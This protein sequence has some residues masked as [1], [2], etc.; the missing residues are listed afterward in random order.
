MQDD[1]I[2]DDGGVKAEAT[3]VD[4]F[5]CCFRCGHVEKATFIPQDEETEIEFK[6]LLHIPSQGSFICRKC[7][8]DAYDVDPE[9]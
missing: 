6:D 9:G 3:A 8:G 7:A 5:C 1:E 4:L 2:H